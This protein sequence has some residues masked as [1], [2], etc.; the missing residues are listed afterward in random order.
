[1]IRPQLFRLVQCFLSTTHYLM[2]FLHVPSF[3]V[4]YGNPHKWGE[5]GFACFILAICAIS[6]RHVD[7]V[8]VRQDASDSLSAGLHY[9]ELFNSIRGSS[10]DRPTMYT[11]QGV[12][13]A[14][15]YAV[16]LGKLSKGSAL[17]AE[18]ITLSIDAGIHRS[19]DLCVYLLFYSC[20]RV[21][22]LLSNLRG[23]SSFP[24]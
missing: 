22:G 2:P 24:V 23:A 8:R 15:V 17:L 10:T 12:F 4:D 11:I 13:V 7:D 9:F 3:L 21:L 6:S 20:L 14:A 19:A 5:S 18:A 16:G 1:M